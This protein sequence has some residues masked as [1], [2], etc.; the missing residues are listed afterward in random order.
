MRCQ[1]LLSLALVA[2]STPLLA[3]PVQHN[4][5]PGNLVKARMAY[6]DVGKEFIPDKAAD[7]SAARPLV[8]RAKVE[9]PTGEADSGSGENVATASVIPATTPSTEQS[10][11]PKPNKSKGKPSGTGTPPPL[12][13]PA[14]QGNAT[15]IDT[16]LNMTIPDSPAATNAGLE[17]GATSLV[18]AV[19][20]LTEHVPGMG[21]ISR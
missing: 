20:H 12:L 13:S 1:P 11:A 9:H 2:I 8:P 10:T 4:N 7:V 14:T 3:A 17:A 6:V 18:T 15:G 5:A 21:L 19:S 16:P